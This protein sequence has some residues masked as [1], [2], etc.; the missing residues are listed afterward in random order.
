LKDLF[1]KYRNFFPGF[2]AQSG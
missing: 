2:E 1:I